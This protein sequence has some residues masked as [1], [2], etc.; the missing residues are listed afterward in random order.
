MIGHKIFNSNVIGRD[1]ML[2]TPGIAPYQVKVIDYQSSSGSHV[3]QMSD[4]GIREVL[5]NELYHSLNIVPD[6]YSFFKEALC[7]LPPP[8]TACL[9]ATVPGGH[10]QGFPDPA[11][12][13]RDRCR[14]VRPSSKSFH[15]FS[16]LFS[17]LE[18]VD[19]NPMR[20]IRNP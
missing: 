9:R 14:N 11:A 20:A 16:Q 6:S 10:Q 5:L 13:P 2:Q 8:P 15:S 4:G 18:S 19:R 1:I 3:I 7:H 12:M 17:V